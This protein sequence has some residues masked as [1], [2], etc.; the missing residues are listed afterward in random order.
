MSNRL[1]PLNEQDWFKDEFI[2]YYEELRLSG[3]EV[4]KKLHEVGYPEMK[5]Y[6][7]YYF[8]KKYGLKSRNQQRKQRTS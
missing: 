2:Y 6:H 7:V 3:E 8:A 1:I 5:L 4:L